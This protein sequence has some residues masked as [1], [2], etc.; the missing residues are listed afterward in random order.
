MH[1]YLYLAIINSLLILLN[2]THLCTPTITARLRI[3]HKRSQTVSSSQRRA[4]ASRNDLTLRK[5]RHKYCILHRHEGLLCRADV[6]QRYGLTTRNNKDT[7]GRQ[8]R[9]ISGI[10][11]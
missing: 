5:R 3:S 7:T 10:D 4:L 11:R 9:G 6:A 8:L 1:S 2:E